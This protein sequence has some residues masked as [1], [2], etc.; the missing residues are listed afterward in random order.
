MEQFAVGSAKFLEALQEL[1]NKNKQ[2]DYYVFL[3]RDTIYI[4]HKE[5]EEDYCY[6]SQLDILDA[7]MALLSEKGFETR[8]DSVFGAFDSDA[9]DI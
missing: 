2:D 8:I 1:R 3:D 4:K 7:F 9:W 6:F 5:N